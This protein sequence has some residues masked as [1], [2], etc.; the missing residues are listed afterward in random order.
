MSTV[1]F[2]EVDRLPQDVED[3]LTLRN[4]TA[5]TPQGGAAMMVLALLLYTEDEELGRQCL[6]IAADRDR[7]Q[8]GPY[9]YRNWQLRTRDMQLINLQL[10]AMPY[11]PRSYIRGATPENGYRLPDPPYH[12]SFAPNLYGGDPA[13]GVFKAFLHC[14][15]ASNP[16]PIMLRRNDKGLWK[17]CEWSSLIVGVREPA[18]TVI[19][20]L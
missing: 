5:S 9:G 20:D 11:L 7:L 18:E 8:E 19:D 16:R 14:S 17:G 15:G 10:K 13:T 6:T 3:F 1:P 4:Q 12:F 2:I